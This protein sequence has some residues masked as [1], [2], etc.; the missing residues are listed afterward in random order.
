MPYIIFFFIP[1]PCSYINLYIVYVIN[2]TKGAQSTRMSYLLC[3]E[4][5]L[6]V[7]SVAKSCDIAITSVFIL[8][9]RF[10]AEAC[11]V[12]Y[13]HLDSTLSGHTDHSEKDLSLPLLSIRLVVVVYSGLSCF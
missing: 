8:R 9:H 4:I 2:Y 10:N 5:I 6:P 11:I 7:V 1:R 12:N 13:Y 3:I